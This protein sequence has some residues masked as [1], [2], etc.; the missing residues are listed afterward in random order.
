MCEGY[1]PIKLGKQTLM[2]G[3]ECEHYLKKWVVINIDVFNPVHLEKT[4][5]KK[6]QYMCEQTS[7][8]VYIHQQ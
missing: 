7:T 6:H 3:N 8:K 4:T 2:D 1:S 5:T